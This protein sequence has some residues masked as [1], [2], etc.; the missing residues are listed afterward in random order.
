MSADRLSFDSTSLVEV[1]IS[2]CPV[3]STVVER[4]D[5]STPSSFGCF[6]VLLID[7]KPDLKICDQAG[8]RGINKLGITFLNVRLF[9]LS[10]SF[11]E[12]LN[13]LLVMFFVCLTS[14]TY[15]LTNFRYQ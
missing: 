9:F 3:F 7:E 6:K 4:S 11:G 14:T 2:C 13:T 15:K 12:K 1:P 8:V 10:E 5:S